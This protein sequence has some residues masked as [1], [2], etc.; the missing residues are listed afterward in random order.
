M[1][2]PASCQPLPTRWPRLALL[3]HCRPRPPNPL[4][5]APVQKLRPQH[6]LALVLVACWQQ[7]E[8]ASPLDAC[9]WTIDGHLPY[10]GFPAQQAAGLRQFGSVLSSR[11][12]TPTG[13]REP[14]RRL[15]CWCNP[16][17]GWAS[18]PAVRSVMQACRRMHAGEQ[19]EGRHMRDSACHRTR[20]RRS[21]ADCA[22]NPP[23]RLP[24]GVP[25]PRYLLELAQQLAQQLGLA[26]PPLSPALWVE[27]Y[28]AE[29]ELPAVGVE[30]ELGRR[31]NSRGRPRVAAKGRSI[32][33]MRG[34]RWHSMREH[35]CGGF[36]PACPS[37]QAAL[38][39]PT[40]VGAT[41]SSP[42]GAGAAAACAAAA[43]C[44]PAC[45]SAAHGCLAR[46]S[47]PLGTVHG[48]AAAGR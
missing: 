13:K 18:R 46:A 11:L 5:C 30:A 44:V 9:R 20:V 32:H 43:L 26:C 8:A 19:G 31:E 24:A 16:H 41:S 17:A 38:C 3:P 34:A 42:S 33:S 12:F 25:T 21:P 15:R 37:T 10:L 47:P 29:L 22:R 45:A 27:R 48:I 1:L 40:R 6:T 4:P 14:W 35:A 23:C 28:L 39:Q 36:S 2:C 7:G